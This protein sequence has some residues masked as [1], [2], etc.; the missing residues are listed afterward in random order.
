[1]RIYT[2]RPLRLKP[3]FHELASQVGHLG[4]FLVSAL[5]NITS[6]G[7]CRPHQPRPALKCR[8]N[9]ERTTL[10]PAQNPN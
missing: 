5:I 2:R 7:F 6:L 10:K 3:T 9:Y 1:L 8:N 4:L